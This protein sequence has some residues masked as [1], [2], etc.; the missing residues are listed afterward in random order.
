MVLKCMS[1]CGVLQ[2]ILVIQG[3]NLV[4]AIEMVF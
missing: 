4:I 2:S 1:M 3:G